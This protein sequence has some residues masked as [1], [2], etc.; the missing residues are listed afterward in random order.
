[1]NSDF[2]LSD[3]LL[4]DSFTRRDSNSCEETGDKLDGVIRQILELLC[5]EHTHESRAFRQAEREMTEVMKMPNNQAS[6][7]ACK[8]GVVL[9]ALWREPSFAPRFHSS[10][11]EQEF[12]DDL[13]VRV[14]PVAGPVFMANLGQRPD[15]FVALCATLHRLWPKQPLVLRGADSART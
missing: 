3:L 5:E 15:S 10:P 6:S 4:G 7:I 8:R 9:F 2:V 12:L 13:Q 14:L 11:A 1:M